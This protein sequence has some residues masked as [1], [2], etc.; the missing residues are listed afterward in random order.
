[1]K[2]RFCQNPLEED[3]DFCSEC[4]KEVVCTPKIVLCTGKKKNGT[5]CGADL[6]KGKKF[7]KKCGAKVD[8]S[9]FEKEVVLCANCGHAFADDEDFCVD[10][11]FPRNSIPDALPASTNEDSA[12][13]SSITK[14]IL[15]PAGLV[16]SQN[17]SLDN[18]FYKKSQTTLHEIDFDTENTSDSPDKEVERKTKEKT[19]IGQIENQPVVNEVDNTTLDGCSRIPDKIDKISFDDICFKKES[20]LELETKSI[21]V[22]ERSVVEEKDEGKL[23]DRNY[24]FDS[25]IDRKAIQEAKPTTNPTGTVDEVKAEKI[26]DIPAADCT[27]SVNEVK[28]E[29]IEDVHAVDPTNLNIDVKE[30]MTDDIHAADSINPINEVKAEKTEDIPAADCINPINEVKAEKTEDIPAADCINPINEVKAE[31]TEDIPAADCINPINE[32][33]AEKT[34]DIPAADSINPIN[35]VKAEKTEDIHAA[36]CTNSGNDV[37]AEKNEDVHVADSTIP[38]DEVKAEKTKDV[39][40]ADSTNSVNE[41]NAE[42]IENVP[43]A[44]S[45]NPVDR[46][47]AEKTKDVHAADSTNSVYEVKAE[48]TE[49]IPAADCINP[50]NEVKAEKTEDI[51]A[52]DCINPIN[53]V[54]AEKT[55]DIPAADSINPIN[56]VK[57]EKIENIPAADCTN[58]GNDV[59]AEKNEDVHVADST[60]PVDEVKAEKTKDVSAADSTNSVNKVNAEKIEN[61][62]AADATNPVDGVDAEKTKDVHAA[63]S[64]NLVY[65]VKAEKTEDIHAVDPNISNDEIQADDVGI[66]LNQETKPTIS[67]THLVEE[68]DEEKIENISGQID[69]EELKTISLEQNV[70]ENQNK[71]YSDKRPV[72][73]TVYTRNPASPVTVEKEDEN[74][75]S[76]GISH[77]LHANGDEE[78]N[79]SCRLKKPIQETTATADPR[80]PMKEESITNSN[81]SSGT[82]TVVSSKCDKNQMDEKTKDIIENQMYDAPVNK[83][84]GINNEPERGKSQT[85]RKKQ[86]SGGK[87]NK[88]TRNGEKGNVKE[89]VRVYFHALLSPEFDLKNADKILVKFGEPTLGGWDSNRHKCTI[90]RRLRDD[91]IEL[92]LER[93][94]SKECFLCKDKR[95]EYKYLVRKKSAKKDIWEDYTTKYTCNRTIALKDKMT[96]IDEWHQ[97]DGVVYFS[98][99]EES[100]LKKNW[101][102]ISRMIWGD[103]FDRHIEDFNYSL[104]HFQPKLLHTLSSGQEPKVPIEEGINLHLEQLLHC[105]RKIYLTDRGCFHSY[106]KYMRQV[107]DCLLMPLLESLAKTSTTDWQESAA[108]ARIRMLK[109]ITVLSVVESFNLDL[110]YHAQDLLARGLL[111][112][113]NH[114]D[115]KCHDLECIAKFVPEQGKRKMI[116]FLKGFM[117]KMAN[118]AKTAKDAFIFLC[119]PLYHFLTGRVRPFEPV[120]YDPSYDK[121]ELKWLG[122]ESFVE[123]VDNYNMVTHSR[124]T[125]PI[126]K[127]ITV[128]HPLFELDYLLPRTMLAVFNLEEVEEAIATGK[129]PLEVCAACLVYFM[130]KMRAEYPTRVVTHSQKR[131]IAAIC[132]LENQCRTLVLTDK[133]SESRFIQTRLLHELSTQL[134]NEALM[135]NV[136]NMLKSATQ[137]FLHATAIYEKL[138]EKEDGKMPGTMECSDYVRTLDLKNEDVR[139]WLKYYFNSWRTDLNNH[140]EIWNSIVAPQTLPS[141]TVRD[142]WN[143]KIQDDLFDILENES[144][145]NEFQFIDMYCRQVDS[146]Q[147]CIQSCLSHLAFEVIEKAYDPDKYN[148]GPVERRH[149]GKLLSDMFL[150]DW[151]TDLSKSKMKNDGLIMYYSFNWM[152]FPLF[153]NM[154]YGDDSKHDLSRDCC[155]AIAQARDLIVEREY[156]L[157]EGRITIRDLKEITAAQ[158]RYLELAT[159]ACK[160][161]KEY[162]DRIMEIRQ[163]EVENYIVQ[164]NYVKELLYLCQ[165]LE[166]VKL[167]ELNRTIKNLEDNEMDLCIHDIC[168]PA[169]M[170]AVTVDNLYPHITAFQLS[171][172]V[173]SMLKPLHEWFGNNIFTKVWIE[174]GSASS[175]E[176]LDEVCEQVWKPAY[177]KMKDIIQRL[178]NG[179]L[180]FDEME[181]YLGNVY[182]GDFDKILHEMIAL[183]L[184]EKTAKE[185]VKQLQQFRE[186][187]ACVRGAKAILNI[188]EDY[189]LNGDFKEIMIIASQ[190]N[191]S[192]RKM[193][194]FDHSVLEVCASLRDLAPEKIDC[195]DNFKKCKPLVMWLRESMPGGLKELKVFVD[196]AMT[197]AGEGDMEIAKVNCLHAATTGYASLIFDLDEDSGYKELLDKCETIWNTLKVDKNLPTKL[198]DAYHLLEQLKTV[199][200]AHGSVEVTSL[201]Q[202]EAISSKGVYNIGAFNIDKD[203]DSSIVLNLQNVLHLTVPDHDKERKGHRKYTFEQLQDLQSRLML[204]AG[205]AE[206]GNEYVDRF[207]L[208]L[209]NVIRL[210]NVFLKLTSAGCVL[211]KHWQTKFLCDPSR[212]VCAFIQFGQESKAIKGRRP[213]ESKAIMGRGTK[214]K[215][216]VEIIR[217]LAQFME[218]CL[219]KWEEHINQK[220]LEYFELNYFTSDQ[221]VILQQELVK[222]D[223]NEG[224]DNWIY[225][226][227]SAVKENC[228]YEDLVDAMRMASKDMKEDMETNGV[229]EKQENKD[230]RYSETEII[231]ETVLQKFIN[232][233]VEAGY[234]EKLAKAALQYVT[235]DNI[236]DGVIWCSEHTEDEFMLG[237]ENDTEIGDSVIEGSLYEGWKKSDKSV[238]ALTAEIIGKMKISH[239]DMD[240]E[241]LIK[242]LEELWEA[243]LSSLSSSVS[244]Y[245]SVEHLGLILRKLAEKKEIQIERQ[246][247]PSFVQGEPNLIVCS[248]AE[249]LSTVLSI[250]MMD[251]Q[252]LP[253]ADEVL[254]CTPQTTLDQLDVFFIRTLTDTSSKI[255]CLVNSDLLDFDVSDGG[256]RKLEQYMQQNQKRDVQYRLVVICS[257]ENEYKSHIIAA[258]DKFRRPPFP[259]IEIRHNV[260]RNFKVLEDNAASVVDF[261]R[262]CVRVVKSHQAGMGKS[263]YVLRRSEELAKQNSHYKAMDFITI[264]LQDKE[265]KVSHV[266]QI[267]LNHIESPGSTT[268]R[269]F[270]LDIAHEVISCSA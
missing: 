232:E 141:E 175:A 41:V 22:N 131:V 95:I 6:Q 17:V 246:F 99:K 224:P 166:H 248:K 111:V 102:R 230:V 186:L 153:L 86:K 73:E 92:L 187:E 174:I 227:L 209:E 8:Q 1:M 117:E 270:H 193:K 263:L 16:L 156:A 134:L 212:P 30:K 24:Q 20:E 265:L 242:D 261:D 27:Y 72:Q 184:S 23:E 139:N 80:T 214:R 223:M 267:L 100:F 116:E 240:V 202:A 51:P 164:K 37:K 203:K 129:M 236:T 178:E 219:K 5:I 138:Q 29:K 251:Q 189:G 137:V 252:P 241:P 237:K 262:S 84:H 124:W 33:K 35:E 106:D 64:T 143:S 245:L 181:T 119:V 132:A 53:E 70:I 140:L 38:V 268:P 3:C 228:N 194:E 234:S 32:V 159:I 77:E 121:Q 190:E 213:E 71:N 91:F 204:V 57:A 60:I 171:Y 195:L 96:N 220:R 160:R 149:F 58:S 25:D 62:H 50:I 239:D 65:E 165:H 109:A 238:S 158:D 254:I 59:K 126:Q 148:F 182:N 130:R 210:A 103:S 128:L 145:T 36:D 167:D 42:K 205:K 244:D 49:D 216:D 152:P 105:L 247:P 161:P 183:K 188:A 69:S 83:V 197:S 19:Q 259:I 54:K 201:A 82:K 260:R 199:K 21:F 12:V 198:L 68:A 233:I 257:S 144:A 269:I 115:K 66:K 114:R 45:I 125:E 191:A 185:R 85:S 87:S 18:N 56:E 13:L 146:F 264:R 43:A 127:V 4:G 218:T 31:K 76:K 98:K 107:T 88:I 93:N 44:D 162:V 200:Q 90:V 215:N 101:Q 11:G 75:K 118:T 135:T 67:P 217:R 207:M 225:P 104:M 78:P 163:R 222:F 48:K 258:L 94:I 28:A 110:T 89:S 250:Y 136:D 266:M 208:I 113:P 192:E 97:Y 34:E 40:A 52:A 154:L 142:A 108:E 255:H 61:V 170:E 180:N 176:S 151:K 206:Q 177:I 122:I 169:S 15:S 235:P 157:E 46:V 231:E 226:L 150:R 155:S 173:L 249:V 79:E 7:C 74:E 196:L 172:E 123:V 14:T 133:S 112:R 26:E 253:Q 221:L 10:C 147:P 81:L 229:V 39:S 120:P 55:E 63:D 243:F 168:E 2:C 47:D 179:D 9:V 211:F 256:E